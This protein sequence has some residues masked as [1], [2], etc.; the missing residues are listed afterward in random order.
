MLLLYSRDSSRRFRLSH[1]FHNFDFY[2]FVTSNYHSTPSTKVYHHGPSRALATCLRPWICGSAL[3]RFYTGPCSKTCARFVN[4][5]S[6]KTNCPFFLPVF[7]IMYRS[8]SLYLCHG[9]RS[10]AFDTATSGVCA[11]WRRSLCTTTRF[12]K[13]RLAP[14]TI[15]ET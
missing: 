2:R 5:T 10:P 1:L 12:P 11:S 13:S 6:A 15:C 14:S 8:W 3:W 9:T 4:S 7:L